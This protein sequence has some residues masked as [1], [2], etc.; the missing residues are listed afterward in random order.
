MC[1]GV[2]SVFFCLVAAVLPF[3]KVSSPPGTVVTCHHCRIVRLFNFP[4]I[5]VF[6]SRSA[7][8]FSQSRFA[9]NKT[10]I[11]FCFCLFWNKQY[12]LCFLF[13]NSSFLKP[14]VLLSPR[15]TEIVTFSFRYGREK[16]QCLDCS[17][18]IKRKLGSH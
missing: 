10:S 1:V 7:T 11:D 18:K 15:S 3:L 13:C 5:S 9:S 17:G 12:L 2:S 16:R 14:L 6:F 8:S 4:P